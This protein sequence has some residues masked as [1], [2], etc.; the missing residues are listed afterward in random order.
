MS[1]PPTHTAFS[2]EFKDFVI[3]IDYRF[4]S[5]ISLEIYDREMY[6]NAYMSDVERDEDLSELYGHSINRIIVERFSDQ[7]EADGASGAVRLAGGDYFKAIILV[8]GQKGFRVCPE[9]ASVDGWMDYHIIEMNMHEQYWD[10]RN[11]SYTC[12]TVDKGMGYSLKRGDLLDYGYVNDRRPVNAEKWGGEYP[13]AGYYTDCVYDLEPG[14][15]G[16]E[17]A[18]GRIV[19]EPKYVYAVGFWNGG[20]EHSVVARFV[21]DKLCWGVINLYGKEIIPCIYPGLYC[22]WGDA[23]AFKTEEDGLYGLMDFERTVATVSIGT[24]LGRWLFL[25][26]GQK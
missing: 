2:I 10:N 8:I 11:P 19:I 15:W 24:A 1:A 14:K 23:V 13:Y 21:D 22:H 16:F 6:F 17:D 7:F 4:Y 12:I 20:G 5:E 18:T 25:K 9:D 26:T 3:E